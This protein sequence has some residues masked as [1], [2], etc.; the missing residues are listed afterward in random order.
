MT[1][2]PGKTLLPLSRRVVD[3]SKL[4]HNIR[5][6]KRVSRAPRFMAVVKA[7]AY[8][9]GVLPVARQALATGVDWLA[10]A[11]VSEAVELRSAGLC[12][13]VLLFGD[14]SEDHLD[15]LAKEEIRITLTDLEQARYLAGRAK[16]MGLCLKAHVKV[17]TG[18]GRLGLY[19]QPEGDPYTD[20]GA[21]SA[22]IREIRRMEGLHL[23]GMYTHFANADI[24]DKRHAG[25]QLAV[26][27]SIEQHLLASG[28]RPDILHAANSAATME[29]PEA[30]FD[31]VRPGIALYGLTPS[32]E[33]DT[34]D[35]ILKP[36]MSIESE[37]IQ[38]KSVPAGFRVSYGST[39][40]TPTPTRI[41]TVPAGYADGYSRLLSSKGAML[42]HGQRA[43][44]LG[45]VCMDFTMIDVGRIDGVKVKD[46]VTLMGCQDEACISADEIAQQTGT[47][48]YEVVA[49]LTR[50]MPLHY[51][52]A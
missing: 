18:M 33:V 50:R 7:D 31:M 44:V 27:Q 12:V 43:P 6:L 8:G 4:A 23:E 38:V 11:R 21:V 34:G 10:V 22:M 28:D 17:D 16:E 26:F 13:P 36:V 40:V 32:D 14:V 25:E 35:I 49:A 47:I 20:V 2:Y 51:I 5:A 39:H 41:A 46:R 37:I 30:H 52:N 45:R 9:H 1:S 42:V 48:N 3:L 24:R 19:R 15:F 29:L